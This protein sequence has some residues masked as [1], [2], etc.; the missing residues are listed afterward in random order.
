V[1]DDRTDDDLVAA[2]R[3]NGEGCRC[4]AHYASE[5][6][7]SGVV[8]G[9]HYRHDAADALETMYAAVDTLLHTVDGAHHPECSS[10]DGSPGTGEELW[11]ATCGLTDAWPC[12]HR[13]VLDALRAS[14]DAH[15]P[16]RSSTGQFDAGVC[17]LCSTPEHRPTWPAARSAER[18]ES[19]K[20]QPLPS[21]HPHAQPG[22]A[23]CWGCKQWGCAAA[24][25]VPVPCLCPGDCDGVCACSC[26]AWVASDVQVAEKME[27]LVT[28]RN[29]WQATAAGISEDLSNAEDAVEDLTEA[30]DALADLIEREVPCQCVPDEVRR[31][32]RCVAF[33]TWREVARRSA[34]NSTRFD[35]A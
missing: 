13:V 10:V 27:Q 23:C 30:G 1:S 16:P 32:V 19:L 17:A 28:E 20:D 29:G 34:T 31:C 35:T 7:C 24:G 9:E 26:H 22:A 21:E 33:L 6:C 15:P 12:A 8:W 11:C 14:R 5:C 2:L 25:G 4:S 18:P 3:S